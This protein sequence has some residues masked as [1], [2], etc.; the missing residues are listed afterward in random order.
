MPASTPTDKLRRARIE[1][2]WVDPDAKAKL[3]S[4]R[5][6]KIFHREVALTPEEI[7]QEPR[8]FREICAEILSQ[9]ETKQSELI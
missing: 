8:V 4:V 2:C 9:P 6:V 5:E 3:Y 7:A 1:A